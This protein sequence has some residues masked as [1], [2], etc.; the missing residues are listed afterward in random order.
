MNP[1]IPLALLLASAAPDRVVLSN[2]EQIEGH[3]LGVSGGRL[4]IEMRIGKG[5]AELACEIRRIARVELGA[6]F[7][8]SS[9]PPD[10]GARLQ[11]LRALWNARAPLLPV[12]GSDAGPIGLALAQALIDAGAAPEAIPLL[13]DIASRHPDA[14][15]RQTADALRVQ[16]LVSR[17]ELDSA[18]DLARS[19]GRE[20]D[21]P[22][23]LAFASIAKGRTEAGRTNLDEAIDHFLRPRILF[24]DLRQEAAQ[25]LWEASQIE[26]ARSNRAQALRWL[27]E[28]LSNYSNTIA[29]S[30]AAETAATAGAA[31]PP[32]KETP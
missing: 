18:L 2:G 16:A 29:F 26:L 27:S 9:L 13:Q 21:D 20:C 28:I 10:S 3:I 1:L 11:S 32:I 6:P 31:P 12:P 4:R 22:S 15:L 7:A 19:L 8:P 23:A 14:A 5:R 24:P 30:K 25:G 17:G